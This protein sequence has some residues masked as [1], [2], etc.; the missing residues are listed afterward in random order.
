MNFYQKRGLNMTNKDTSE[1]E[2][3]LIKIIST[4]VNIDTASISIAS[5]FQ[6][7][8]G[9]D[10]LDTVELLM[11][12]EEEFGINISDEEAEKLRTVGDAIEFIK[13]RM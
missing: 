11:E 10:S 12:L 2:S 3:K 5:R 7:D 1:L 9:L 6:E 8:L 13:S 4:K